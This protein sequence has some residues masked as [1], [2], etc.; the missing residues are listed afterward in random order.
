MSAEGKYQF[1]VTYPIGIEPA[2]AVGFSCSEGGS[3][4]NRTGRDEKP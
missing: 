1:I 3:L 2:V 4:Q